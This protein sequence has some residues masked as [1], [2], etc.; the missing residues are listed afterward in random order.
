MAIIAIHNEDWGF[1]TNCFVCEP[2]NS[3]GLRIPFFHDTDSDVVFAHFSLGKEFSGAPTVVHGGLSL[4]VLDEA[5]A[6]ACIASGH[7][8]AVTA[9]TTTKFHGAVYIGKEHRVEGRVIEVNE[10]SMTTTGSIRDLKGRVRAEATATFTVLGVAQA[11]RLVGGE[12]DTSNTSYVRP[13]D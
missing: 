4:A 12:I 13:T 5:M 8:W 1:E 9:E 11:Q 10:S 3:L 2:K 7:R 6:W